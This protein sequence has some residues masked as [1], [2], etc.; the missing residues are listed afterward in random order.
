MK[1]FL[2]NEKNRN[3]IY[4]ILFILFFGWII[5]SGQ[6]NQRKLK[7]GPSNYSIAVITKLSYGSRVSPWFN[8]KFKVKNKTYSSR[9]NIND[10]M[11]RLPGGVLN[12]YIGK[13]FYVKFY[14]ADPDIN[15][16]LV[17]KPVPEQIQQA[18]PEGWK[19]IPKV[20]KKKVDE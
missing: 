12:A 7:K 4:A 1:D 2:K 14:V 15:K 10:K 18:P 19:G 6:L 9:Y 20:V 16:L 17:Y 13:R 5:I 3:I 8:Y 11:R